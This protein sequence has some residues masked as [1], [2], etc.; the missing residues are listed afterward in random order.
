MSIEIGKL[1]DISYEL[2]KL[3]LNLMYIKQYEAARSLEQTVELLR[4]EASVKILEWQKRY[5]EREY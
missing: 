5:A 3:A 4:K 1:L 2:E